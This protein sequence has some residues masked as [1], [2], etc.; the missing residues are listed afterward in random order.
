MS[1]GREVLTPIS[2]SSHTAPSAPYNADTDSEDS[3]IQVMFLVW[4]SNQ[5]QNQRRKL[6]HHKATTTCMQS[7]T[8]E[9]NLFRSRNPSRH[10]SWRARPATV[11]H[12]LLSWAVGAP[13]LKSY[14]SP[15]TKPNS[16]T[17]LYHV[18][19]LLRVVINGPFFS[20]FAEISRKREPNKMRRVLLLIS[21]F[22]RLQRSCI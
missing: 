3:Y 15:Y 2:C 8:P 18:I 1:P 7:K 21:C 6:H 11:V 19:T 5:R 14:L 10:T 16:H 9:V 13:S 20:R 4:P 12:S 22:M 17:T